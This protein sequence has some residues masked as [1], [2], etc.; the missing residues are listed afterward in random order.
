MVTTADCMAVQN[1]HAEQ[2]DNRHFQTWPA[3][4][5]CSLSDE[6]AM[7]IAIDSNMIEEA[8]LPMT[9]DCMCQ[10][11]REQL[12]QILTREK[13]LNP[14]GSMPTQIKSLTLTKWRKRLAE[15]MSLPVS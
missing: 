8:F 15:L 13:E 7:K 3:E 10:M 11:F 12:R 14:G 9:F 6:Q 2:P 1:L 5:Y 4:V